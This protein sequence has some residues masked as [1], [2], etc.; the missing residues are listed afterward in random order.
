MVAAFLDFG[1]RNAGTPF[2]TASMPVSAVVPDEKARATRK[3]S[4]APVKE[5]SAT[6]S[7]PALSAR[8]VSPRTNIS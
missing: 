4:A 3:I 7:Q 2:A 5:F 6:I 8:R 1:S